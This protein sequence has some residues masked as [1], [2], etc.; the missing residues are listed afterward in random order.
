MIQRFIYLGEGYSDLY[1]LME[2]ARSN[3]SRIHMLVRLDTTIQSEKKCSLVV[4]LK[5][6]DP[7]KLM[8]L[9]VS[10]EGFYQP[11]VKKT[12]RYRLFEQLSTDLNQPIHRLEV[13][14][15]SQFE[16]LDL[17]YQYLIGVLR[18]NRYIPPLQ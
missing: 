3:H 15:S 5:P 10:L 11:D 14:A 12:E 8:P 16:E 1:E 9:Y 18:L 17:F 4:I 6:A 7:G 13:K 2:I